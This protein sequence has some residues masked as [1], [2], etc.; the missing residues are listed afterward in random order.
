MVILLILLSL[1]VVIYLMATELTK[2]ELKT[3]LWIFAVAGGLILLGLL[4]GSS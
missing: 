1:A 3:Y 2:I 4:T